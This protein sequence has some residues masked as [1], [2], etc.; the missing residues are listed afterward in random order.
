[1]ISVKGLQIIEYIINQISTHYSNIS[2][3]IISP[4]NESV[5][6]LQK[7]FLS[8]SNLDN[9]TIETIDRIQGMTVDYSI[10]YIPGRNP[11][12][13]LDERRF[14]VATSRS[15]STTMII[16]DISL[17]NLHT[18]PAKVKYYIERCNIVNASLV[19]I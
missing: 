11:G 8:Y 18:I 7:S 5:K 4:F 15:R 19:S 3:A 16:T 13:A 10:L 14:N 2:V 1:M 9:L 6:Q 12:F 17:E